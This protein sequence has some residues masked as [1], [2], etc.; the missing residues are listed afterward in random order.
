MKRLVAALVFVDVVMGALVLTSGHEP[1]PIARDEPE[2]S[3]PA[4][5]AT[6]MDGKG[7]L[8]LAQL[9]SAKT[10]TLLWFWAPWCPICNEEAPEIQRL[11][12]DARDELA[13]VGI[14]GRDDFANAP[15]IVARRRLSSPTLLF[16]EAMRVWSAYRIPAQPGAVLLD[17]N[18][19]EQPRWLGAFDNDLALDGARDL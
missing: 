5:T 9:A 11:A 19:R 4:P 6:R 8:D 1:A 12:E 10:P 15:E 14:G 17:R 16:D 13:V 18:G 2:A 3:V 7:Q